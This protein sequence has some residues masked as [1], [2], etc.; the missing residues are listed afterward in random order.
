VQAQLHFKLPRLTLD[1]HLSPQGIRVHEVCPGA[2]SAR[3]LCGLPLT[4]D[5]STVRT[6]KSMAAT[7][8]V[9]GRPTAL[10]ASLRFCVR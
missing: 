7:E 10:R 1:W 2:E 4:R 6:P 9:S 3:L 5:S 8:L